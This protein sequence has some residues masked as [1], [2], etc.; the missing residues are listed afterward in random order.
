MAS[1]D[2]GTTAHQAHEWVK[3]FWE[4]IAVLPKES[5]FL[6]TGVLTPTEF[7]AA[8]DI[9]R[10]KCPLWEWSAG[11]ASKKKRYLPDN[12]Q[13]LI[14]RGAACNVRATVDIS[15]VVE[16]DAALAG[17][18][19]EGWVGTF[20]GHIPQ[21]SSEIIEDVVAGDTRE[22]IA[23]IP[24]MEDFSDDDNL[25]ENDSDVLMEDGFV[26]SRTYDV[27]ITYDKFYMVPRLWLFGYAEDGTP[28][29]AQAMTE[30]VDASVVNRTMTYENH[31]HSP[32]KVVSIHPCRH[33]EAM[34]AF[35]AHYESV[36]RPINPEHAML[37]FLKVM[38]SAIP[39]ISIDFTHSM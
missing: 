14:M 18:E 37:L 12:K 31:P 34:R 38:S 9:L 6:E 29:S 22:E 4:K 36:G 19:K 10:M 8:G 33:A 28:L 15:E 20:A 2:S 17:L 26:R 30:D 13:Y 39:T 25:V 7:V 1:L 27:S 16:E 35:I 5:K 21:E 24:D 11:D 23:G 3:K 32:I